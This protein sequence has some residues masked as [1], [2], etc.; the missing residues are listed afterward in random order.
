MVFRVALTQLTNRVGDIA[1]NA[2]QMKHF[3]SE[4][5]QAGADLIVFPELALTGYPPEDLLLK[6]EMVDANIAAITELATSC[7]F[8]THAVVG[9]VGRGDDLADDTEQWD[10]PQQNRS[11]TNAASVLAHGQ[12]V[13]TYRKQRLP[14]YGVFDERR[15][16]TSMRDTCVVNVHGVRVGV[17]ICEDLWSDAGPGERLVNA[18]ID[19][20]VVLNASPYH[21]GKRTDREMW[22][23]T[24]ALRGNMH[25]VYVNTVGGQDEVVFD[26]DSFV[27]DPHGTVTARL[28]QFSEDFLICDLDLPGATGRTKPERPVPVALPRLSPEAETWAALVCATRDYCHK[29]GFR[30]AVI[31]LSGGIDSAVTAAIAVDALGAENVTGVAMPSPYSSEHSLTDARDAATLLGITL[32]EVP[33]GAPLAAFRDVL[34]GLVVTD[35]HRSDGLQPGVAYE[36]MQSRL[37]GL[38]VMALSNEQNAIVLTTGNKSEYAVGYATLYGDMAGGYAPLKDVEKTLVFTLANWR[39]T[40]NRVIPES[41]VTK[42]P[43][44]ELR[45]GQFDS[46]SLPDYP[47]LDAIIRMYVEE[48]ASL[49]EIVASGIDRDTAVRTIALIDRAEFKR[50]QAAPGPKIT[51]RAFGRDRRMPITQLWRD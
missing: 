39:N 32:H 13:A 8:E 6:R 7:M 49:A 21:R 2:T 47:V 35:F 34:D 19:V 40:Q 38:T 28:A 44:A 33:I 25:V 16:F 23:R 43:S 22:C 5:E 51:V 11:L 4:A 37:R 9:H 15:Y 18:G 27:I 24:Y 42:P 46:D 50:R 30:H 3:W 26:G 29:N 10:A 36:N 17:L 31:G 48:A 12:T 20:M 45:P 1:G 41:S 14:N